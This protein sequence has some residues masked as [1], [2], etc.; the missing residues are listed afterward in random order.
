MHLLY[1]SM[2]WHLALRLDPVLPLC[3]FEN[4]RRSL[5]HFNRTWG[6]SPNSISSNSILCRQLKC[7]K[8]TTRLHVGVHTLC[9]ISSRHNRHW[10]RYISIES[11]TENLSVACFNF[12]FNTASG[13]LHRTYCIVAIVWFLRIPFRKRFGGPPYPRHF[14]IQLTLPREFLRM[15]LLQ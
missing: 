1:D 15:V 3:K 11:W 6:T 13:Y 4:L 7:V 10:G 5:Q 8:K 12:N 2:S 14:S 9:H